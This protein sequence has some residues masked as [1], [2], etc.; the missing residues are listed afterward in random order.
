MLQSM[1]VVVLEERPFTVTRPDGLPVWI[2]QFKMSPHK[3]VPEVPPGPERDATA[4]AL[5]RCGDRDLAR[6]RRDR[7]IQRTRPACRPHLAAGGG[8]AQLREVSEA[9]GFP[10]QP[11]TYRDRDQRQRRNRT[12]A[13]RT[14]R[15]AVLSDV[16]DGRRA[17]TARC[18]GRRRGRR[19]RHRR[20]GQPGH[21][22]RP[23]RIRV[24][25]P[26][27][28]AHQLFRHRGRSPRARR[29]SCPSSSIPV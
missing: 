18:P 21:R 6:P 9:G 13:R 5:R 1:G 3:S 28:A 8:S 26:G 14:L 12:V 4:G 11:V 24:D 23:A 2:Y 29:T 25:D 27:D 22:P 15:G 17:A 10:V 19:R 16:A 7:S 20:A